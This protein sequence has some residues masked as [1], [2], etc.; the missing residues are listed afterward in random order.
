ML[1]ALTALLYAALIALSLI[2]LKTQRLPDLITLPLI[3][4]GFIASWFFLDQAMASAIGAIAGY[5]AFFMV[6]TL[7]KR[8][9]G[10]D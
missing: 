2:D 3:A 4:L 6:E 7:Y 5:L 9:R 1:L 10:F 8:A